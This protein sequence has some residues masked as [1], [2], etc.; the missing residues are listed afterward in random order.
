M[1][2]VPFYVYEYKS[3]VI[4]FNQASTNKL[5]EID[6]NKCDR[7]YEKLECLQYRHIH[8]KGYLCSHYIISEKKRQRISLHRRFQMIHYHFNHPTFHTLALAKRK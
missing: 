7:L 5:N 1:S 2:K 8:D 3:K 4:F 6:V